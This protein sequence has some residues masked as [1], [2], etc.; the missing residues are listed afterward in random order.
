MDLYQP[1]DTPPHCPLLPLQCKY[2]LT[3][4][5][6]LPCRVKA[7]EVGDGCGEGGGA[8]RSSDPAGV[9]MGVCVYMCVGTWA[10]CTLGRCGSGSTGTGAQATTLNNKNSMRT[11][12]ALP[13]SLKMQTHTAQ[14]HINKTTYLVAGAASVCVIGWEAHV[15]KGKK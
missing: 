11:Q 5:A 6:S 9:C 15:D 7:M 10:R 14:R 13:S 3:V 2:S 1:K 12:G 8:P 4:P